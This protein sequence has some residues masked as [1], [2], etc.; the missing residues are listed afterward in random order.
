MGWF[1]KQ[2]QQRSNLDQQ[3][4]EDSLF[5]AVGIVMGQRQAKQVSG[6]R[7]QNDEALKARLEKLTP[8]EALAAAKELGL[9]FTAEEL[10][11]A[12]MDQKLALDELEAAAGGVPII[13]PLRQE[14]LNENNT[15]DCPLGPGGKH[16]WVIT[17]HIEEP[18][19]F[20]WMDYT[21]GYDYLKCSYCGT[22]Q[23]KRT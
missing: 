4:F 22:E 8:A 16:D 14:D 21:E 9:D 15:S 23:K 18:H 20:L 5:R 17:G 13:R 3:L 6:E 11:E 7:I 19:K 10:K 2:I 1:E 12:A